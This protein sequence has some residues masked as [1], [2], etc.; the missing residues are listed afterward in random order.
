[1][2]KEPLRDPLE[3]L[4]GTALRVYLLLLLEGRP[5]GVREVQ[6]R[7]GLRSPST[8][9]HHLERLREL[10]LVEYTGEGYV[11]RPP[12]RG[13]LT[14]FAIVRGRLLPLP[15]AAAAFTAAAAMAY[16]LL[17]GRDPAAVAVLLASAA[18]QALAAWRLLDAARG[19]KRLVEEGSA[20]GK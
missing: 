1:L 18:V 2:E 17:P 6:R 20:A 4:S 11:A 10:G 3:E 19:L 16:A 5:M 13:L 14:A 15:F 7:L 9:R 8:A 12:R